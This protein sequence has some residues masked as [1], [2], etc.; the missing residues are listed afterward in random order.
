MNVLQASIQHG[1]VTYALHA[2]STNTS[3][4]ENA[5]TAMKN[6][7]TAISALLT[8]QTL[9]TNGFVMHALAQSLKFL[10]KTTKSKAV[11]V[12]M[13]NTSKSTTIQTLKALLVN[14]AFTESPTAIHANNKSLGTVQL[15]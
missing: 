3:K 6:L 8:D 9:L 14:H 13:S 10:M 7:I 11:N 12:T 15:F 1:E 5:D 4:L 2:H